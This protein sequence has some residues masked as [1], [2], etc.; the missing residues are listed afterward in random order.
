VIMTAMNA[1]SWINEKVMDWLGDKNVAD[2]LSQSVPNNITSEMGLALLDV[3][4]VIRPHPEVVD[5]LRQVRDDSFLDDLV[6]FD[7]GQ[8]S[9]DA[10]CAFLNKYGMRC[11]GEIDITKP[12]WSEKPS[13]IVPMILGNIKNFAP[14]ASRLK[15][16]QGRQ[17]AL[18]KERELLE[19][20][21]QLPDGEQKAQETS[22]MISLVRNLS[23]YREY[24]KYGIVSRYF[25]YKQAL[26]IEAERLARAKVIR[27][28]E[29]IYYLAFEEFR[30]V[31]R[32]NDLN[33]EVIRKRKSEYRSYE[34][35][36][37]PR[38]ITSDGEIVAGAYKRENL[39]AGAIVGLPVS[40]GVIEG[41]A[42]VILNLEEAVLEDGD[43]LVTAFTDPSWTPLFVSIRG[44]VT[45]VGGLMTH[46]AVI[47]REYGLPAVVGVENAT[48]LIKDGQRIR[49][50]G[51]EGYVEILL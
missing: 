40:S 46:G 30:E 41:R 1:S 27:D 15:F 23:G 17:E 51:T 18:N 36:T 48:R 12:R 45:E 28:K 38:V 34:K 29:D 9:R 24:P 10:I 4:D 26:L 43:I 5:Y 14:N 3:A 33:Y 20:L 13:T 8:E 50:H 47:A 44:L 7:G 49:V 35:M 21:K 19:Q 25:V 2:T 31:V 32:C 39:P 16:E 22:R 42:R 11:A 6:Q 37:P